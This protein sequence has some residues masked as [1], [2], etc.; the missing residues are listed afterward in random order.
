MV[1]TIIDS[2]DE[3]DH[4]HSLVVPGS[5]SECNDDEEGE[6]PVNS[7]DELGQPIFHSAIQIKSLTL[8]YR[9]PAKGLGFISLCILPSYS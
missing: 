1:T 9:A 5:K 6:E 3:E 7:E 2:D 4:I 8:M